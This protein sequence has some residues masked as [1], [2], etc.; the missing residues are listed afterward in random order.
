MMEAS[1]QTSESNP[2]P[3]GNHQLGPGPGDR[4]VIQSELGRGSM[5][6]VF[7]ARDPLAVR[8]VRR[9]ASLEA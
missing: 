4:Y 1:Q 6:V 9:T 2:A 7:K 5:G 3:N 8:V